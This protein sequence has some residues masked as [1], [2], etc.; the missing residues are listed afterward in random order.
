MIVLNIPGDLPE[1]F[2]GENT[3]QLIQ[4]AVTWQHALGDR[5]KARYAHLC[6]CCGDCFCSG[7]S[8]GI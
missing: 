5:A 8:L 1:S 7:S 2:C 6:D 3:P 4:A